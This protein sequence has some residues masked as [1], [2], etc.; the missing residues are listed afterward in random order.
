M[1]GDQFLE[2]GNALVGVQNGGLQF[3]DPLLRARVLRAG[4]YT[5]LVITR[6]WTARH[7]KELRSVALRHCRFENGVCDGTPN[8]LYDQGGRRLVD[9]GCK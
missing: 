8:A 3:A 6:G 2:H 4:W 5:G 9:S 1:P 7:V